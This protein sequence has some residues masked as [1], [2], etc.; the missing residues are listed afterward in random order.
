V[1]GRGEERLREEEKGEMDRGSVR[2]WQWGGKGEEKR[3]KKKKEEEKGSGEGEREE[4]KRIK[5][6]K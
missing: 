6:S 5:E 4:N 1:R 2:A 3:K